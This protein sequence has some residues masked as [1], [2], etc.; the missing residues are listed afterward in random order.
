M[1][2]NK[3]LLIFRHITNP[4]VFAVREDAFLDTVKIINK[5]TKKVEYTTI[6]QLNRQLFIQVRYDEFFAC[7]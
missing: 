5:F 7:K 2:T 6:N 4:N 1:I 3:G